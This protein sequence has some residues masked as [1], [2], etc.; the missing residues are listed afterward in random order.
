MNELDTWLY[1]VGIL[2]WMAAHP[3]TVEGIIADYENR[4]W[5]RILGDLE[6]EDTP[7]NRAAVS[8]WL[9]KVRDGSLWPAEIVKGWADQ[10]AEMVLTAIG[11]QG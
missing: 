9:P 11:P 1:W 5:A 8:E 2:A 4:Q 10:G 3:R 6:L 7:E